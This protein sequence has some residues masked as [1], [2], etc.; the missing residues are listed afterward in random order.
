MQFLELAVA[1][2]GVLTS[3]YYGPDANGVYG[4][5]NG[6]GGL[7]AVSATPQAPSAIVS[8]IRGNGYAVY[9]QLSLNWYSSRPS[10]FGAIPGYRPLPLGAGAGLAE[11][12]AAGGKWSD[13]TGLY[14][15]GCRYYDPIGGFWM[16]F[17]PSLNDRDPTGYTYCGGNPIGYRDPDGRL[18]T[19]FGNNMPGMAALNG[20]A[21]FVNNYAN[22]SQNQFLGPIAAFAGQVL[23]E[24]ASSANPGTYV[25]GAISFGN[26]IN[27]VYQSGG[28]VDATSYGL[29][30]WN[31]GAVMSGVA[32]QDQVTGQPV[33]DWYQ[34][35]TVISGGVAGTAGVA[36]AGLSGL[37]A[38]TD[39]AANSAPAQITLNRQAGLGF[40][41][42]VSSSLG[43]TPAGSMVG[44]TLSGSSYTTIPD[45]ILPNG[46]LLEVKNGAYVSYSPQ[47]QAQVSVGQSTGVG[48]VLVVNPSSTVSQPVISAFGHTPANPTIF[49]FDPATSVL[50]PYP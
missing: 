44:T 11:A 12:S 3:K 22:N 45:G 30:S 36:S 14:W 17:D 21:S 5:M 1:V 16:S 43:A 46:S 35:G 28:A 34:R 10:A 26:N 41:Q 27:T 38:L 20:A 31:V 32:N 18:A 47:L 24:G 25:N 49:S 23:N 48:N 19:Q 29:T 2:N 33:G 9:Q 40:Q 37:T 15:Y 8:D 50:T 4:G 13:I 7:E 6:V 39:T 42:Q